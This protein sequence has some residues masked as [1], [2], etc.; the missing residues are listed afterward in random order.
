M[1]WTETRDRLIEINEEFGSLPEE[2]Y[3]RTNLYGADLRG[4]N[5]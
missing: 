1:N 3:W 4:A 5:L 2:W